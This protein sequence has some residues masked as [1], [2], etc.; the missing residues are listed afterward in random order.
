MQATFL[1]FF[2]V[3]LFSKFWHVPINES[4]DHSSSVN[5]SHANSPMCCSKVIWLDMDDIC[6][7]ISTFVILNHFFFQI[8]DKCIQS[9]LWQWFVRCYIKMYSF[10]WNLVELVVAASHWR[11]WAW[12]RCCCRKLEQVQSKKNDSLMLFLDQ[13]F[14]AKPD[15]CI[16][17]LDPKLNYSI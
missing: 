3:S 9:A 4:H 12:R 10:Y 5:V 16:F 17:I 13:F 15:V 2:V 11:T 1:L 14:D 7:Y 6:S 8:K